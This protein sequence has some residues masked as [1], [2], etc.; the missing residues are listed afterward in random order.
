MESD[1]GRHFPSQ[2][3]LILL[4]YSGETPEE[5]SGMYTL[6]TVLQTVAAAAVANVLKQADWMDRHRTVY[7]LAVLFVLRDDALV[8]PLMPQESKGTITP[9][10]TF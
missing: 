5:E 7:S 8:C 6:L 3:L 10:G 4:C 9:L 1:R 2:L